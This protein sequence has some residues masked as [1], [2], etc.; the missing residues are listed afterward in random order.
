MANIFS[1]FVVCLLTPFLEFFMVH[2]CVIL[3]CSTRA[4]FLIMVCVLYVNSK[5]PI[6]QNYSPTCSYKYFQIFLFLLLFKLKWFQ[7]NRKVARIVQRTPAYP[8]HRLP[9]LFC[10][11]PYLFSHSLYI[12]NFFHFRVNSRHRAPLPLNTSV[13]IS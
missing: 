11:L 7:T 6:E 10:I 9:Q 13:Y 5:N 1:S 3:L 4:F 2:E 12:Y 8:S